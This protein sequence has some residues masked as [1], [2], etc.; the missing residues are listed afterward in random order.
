VVA[1]PAVVVGGKPSADVGRGRQPTRHPRPPAEPPR[2]QPQQTAAPQPRRP[3]PSTAGAPN[4]F[5]SDLISER[6][7]DEVILGYL[8]EEDGREGE[9]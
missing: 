7:L 9:E 6:S 8:A 2:R 4:L 1:R 5:G 3:Q